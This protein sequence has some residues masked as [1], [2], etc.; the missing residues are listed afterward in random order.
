MPHKNIQ[1]LKFEQPL[2][3]LH[4]MVFGLK[5]PTALT[6]I[7]YTGPPPDDLRSLDNIMTRIIGK[8][9]V[10]TP[11]STSDP[12]RSLLER[13][14]FWQA[15]IQ[16]QARIPT[17]EAFELQA[18]GTDKNKETQPHIYR[19]AL[20]YI[21]LKCTALT[22]RWLLE[23]INQSWQ[24]N[25]VSEPIDSSLNKKYEELKSFLLQRRVGGTNLIHFLDASQSLQIPLTHIINDIYCYGHG[26]HSQLLRSSLTE[27]TCAISVG[28][29]KDKFQCAKVLQKFGIPVAKH[30]FATDENHAV[31]IAFELGY[32][33]VIKPADEDQGRGV[34]AGLKNDASVRIAFKEAMKIS[35]SI[36][37][38]KHHAGED[39]R[40]T[41][42]DDKVIKIMHRRAG[43]IIGDGHSTVNNLVM[44][45][46][47]SESSLK[48][49]RSSG[50]HRLSLDS[51]AL[52]LLT[53]QNLTIES[54]IPKGVFIPLRRKAN[55]S[56]GGDFNVID[57]SSVHPDNVAIAIRATQ[58][59]RLDIAGI[60]LIIP[61]VSTTWKNSNAIICE[62]NA[63]PQIGY[64]D[65]PEI[66]EKILIDIFPQKGSIPLQLWIS[67]HT[68]NESIYPL[69]LN[70]ATKSGVHAVSINSHNWINKVPTSGIYLDAFM[71][72]Q[73]LLCDQRV[74]SAAIVMTPNEIVQFGLPSAYFDSI[75]ILTDG[76]SDK[77]PGAM[78]PLIR[79]IRK[80]SKKIRLI[81]VP[82]ILAKGVK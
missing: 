21:D 69:L 67:E 17:A 75:E 15:R 30:A 33:V 11:P 71:S 2:S 10:Y 7:S 23:V 14:C 81:K 3:G 64:R 41:V 12:I 38:E 48:V 70:K 36:L 61:D 62:V 46:Q 35:K 27:N 40:F 53:E 24:I 72:A 55:I 82:E 50:K 77:I 43:G 44:H 5:V 51:E 74:R 60:D 6:I 20:G 16:R 29:A 13:L 47:E 65:T 79:I 66:F 76:S 9:A 45:L 78:Q 28:L 18:L 56:A 26:V 68:I 25:H 73:A 54:I 8:S 57:I 63:Q 31:D 59:L 37:V 80:H 42:M 1:Y 58:A 22:L 52:D 19:L 49:L 34:Y 4:G 32:P 39:Y